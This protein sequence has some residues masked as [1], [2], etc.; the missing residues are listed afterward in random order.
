MV[1]R[2]GEIT[3]DAI[4]RGWPHQV[5][6]PERLSAR[7]H[8]HPQLEFCKGMDMSPRGHAFVSDGEWWNVK[9]F[10]RREDAEKFVERFGGEFIDPARRPRRRQSKPA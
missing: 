4:N 3:D 6:L 10:A 5:A 1:R 8:F 7:E 2:K 9:C